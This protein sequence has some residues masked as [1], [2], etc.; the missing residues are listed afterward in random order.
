MA[1]PTGVPY[2]H[3]RQRSMA[4]PII[5]IVIGVFFLLAN[6][7][8][9]AWSNF[10]HWYARFWPL[11]II[12]WGLIKLFEYYDARRRNLPT[13]GVGIGAGALIGLLFFTG[14]IA[15]SAQHVNWNDVGREMDINMGDIGPF[16]NSYEFTDEVA[17]PI[18]PGSSVQIANDYG[19]VTVSTWDQ[20]QI[21]VVAHKRVV[22]ADE[23]AGKQAS[24][25]TKP[26]FG[27]S[28][29]VITVN[30]NTHGSGSPGTQRNEVTSN[31]E[32]FLPQKG[33]V[34]IWARH[35]DI[36]VRNRQGSVKA[37]TQHG[38]ATLQDI[39]GNTQVTM[40]HGGLR[41]ENITGDFTADGHIGD[42]EVS[43]VSGVVKLTADVTGNLKLAK[44]AKGGQFSS[45][46]TDLKVGKLDGEL[47][48]DGGELR[49]NDLAGPFQ[50]QTR[51]KNI[52]L[53]DVTGDVRVQ[54]TNGE[55]SVHATKLPL[56]NIEIDN[57]RGEV[58][59]VVPS[60][61]GFQVQATTRRGEIESDFASVNVSN[62]RGGTT[63][64]S[65]SVG[66]AAT[67]VQI[68]NEFGNIQIRKA[69]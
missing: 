69:G 12:L 57:R 37:D 58:Q 44:L 61:A 38:D 9:I 40:R 62:T 23:N 2:R 63:T 10:G 17:Q 36:V 21:K 59:I 60:N 3:Y 19:D 6:T 48:M 7:H 30:A 42:A 56:G 5:L 28:G 31:L 34:D 26:F 14:F 41:A 29:S 35:G 49:A 55:V 67:H 18:K 51:S 52:Y 65:G 15:S 24:D 68:T 39:V 16:G 54:N 1:S 66:S 27:T 46:R 45:S 43:N 25:A 33:S 53:D 11:L 13:P 32:V 4:G 47:N 64:A 50:I 20:N 8:V 22:A